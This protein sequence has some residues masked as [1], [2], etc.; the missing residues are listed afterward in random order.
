MA[1][2]QLPA[3]LHG[4][5]RVTYSKRKNVNWNGSLF[6][7]LIFVEVGML[8]RSFLL[9]NPTDLKE[10]NHFPLVPNWAC[11]PQTK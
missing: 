8:Q 4:G 6:P 11:F 1:D 10:V 3:S 9:L 7:F 5:D 2:P